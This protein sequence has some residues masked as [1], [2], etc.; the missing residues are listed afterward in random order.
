MASSLDA[1]ITISKFIEDRYLSIDA[2]VNAQ[3]SPSLPEARGYPC[4][5]SYI[6]ED[7]QQVE[8]SYKER[9]DEEKLVFYANTSQFTVSLSLSSPGDIHRKPIATWL[10][11]SGQ[12]SS[13]LPITWGMDRDFHGY[14]KLQTALRY[15]TPEVSDNEKAK[16]RL[17]VRK[18]VEELHAGGFVHP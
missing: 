14:L 3:I 16:V 18:I 10:V 8:F 1:L 11:V 5:T 17:K 12:A 4:L 15:D 13:L 6:D 2:E 7:G 9:I